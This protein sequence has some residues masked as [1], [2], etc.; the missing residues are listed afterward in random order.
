[1][2][3][4]CKGWEVPN[5]IG[6]CTYSHTTTN[7]QIGIGT[8][9]SITHTECEEWI[10][11]YIRLNTICMPRCERPSVLLFARDLS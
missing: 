4:N 8:T 7:T 11:L 9:H 10:Y 5:V 2:R 6:P 3:R 1:M